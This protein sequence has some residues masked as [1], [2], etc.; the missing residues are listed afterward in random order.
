MKKRVFRID[1]DGFNGVWYSSATKSR[2]SEVR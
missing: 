2:R 1:K